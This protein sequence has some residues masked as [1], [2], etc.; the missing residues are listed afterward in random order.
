MPSLRVGRVGVIILLVSLKVERQFQGLVLQLLHELL[1]EHKEFPFE[2]YPIQEEGR[3]DILIRTSDGKGFCVVELKDP[4]AVPSPYDAKAWEQ[5]VKYATR[6][7]APYFIT[8]N[9]VSAVVWDRSKPIQ[10]SNIIDQKL[11]LSP[12]EVSLYRRERKLTKEG[13]RKLKDFLLFTLSALLD[14]SRGKVRI[15]GL[16][17]AFIPRIEELLERY[18][19]LVLAEGRIQGLYEKDPSFREELLRYIVEEQGWRFSGQLEDFE[20]LVRLALLLLVTKVIFYKALR[21]QGRRR[22]LPEFYP[23][24]TIRKMSPQKLLEVL[25]S[26]NEYFGYVVGRID[27][28]TLLGEHPNFLDRLP[29][30]SDYAPRFFAELAERLDEYDFSKIPVDVVGKIFEKLIEEDRRHKMG[31]YFTPV[32]VVDLILGYAVRRGTEDVLDAGSGSGT[33]S[34]RAYERKRRLSGKPHPEL[35]EHL[36]AVEIAPYPAHLTTLNLVIRDLRYPSYPRVIQ[37]DFFNL[38]PGSKVPA[39]DVRGRKITIPLP[40]VD[41]VVSNPPYTRQ[42]EMEEIQKGLK[43]RAHKRAAEDWRKADPELAKLLTKRAS[44]YTHFFLHG[45]AFLKP[46]GRLGFVTSNSWLDTDYG[47]V[48]QALLLRHFKLFAVIDSAVERWFEAADVNTCITLA[49]RCESEKERSRNLVRFVSLRAPLSEL[50]EG[51][52]FAQGFLEELESVSEPGFYENERYRVFA[53][54][55]GELLREA[56][57]EE[58]KFTGAKWGK[59]LRAPR[60]YF[61]IL[62]RAKDRLVPLGEIAEV[63]RGFTTGANKFFYVKDITAEFDDERARR[64]FGMSLGEIKARGLAII[65]SGD[66]SIHLIEREY[67]RP[68]VKSLREVK[69]VFVDKKDVS[70]FIVIFPD[71]DIKEFARKY[72]NYGEAQ[73]YSESATCSGR[74]PWFRLPKLQLPLIGISRRFGRRFVVFYSKEVL[75]GDNIYAMYPPSIGLLSFL[76]SFPFSLLHISYG[77]QMSAF[78]SSEVDAISLIKLPVLSPKFWAHLEENASSTLK[79]MARRRVLPILQELGFPEKAR[80][81]KTKEYL[82]RLNCSQ[83]TLDKVKPDRLELDRAVLEAMGFTDP[84]ERD[85]VLLELY[86]ELCRLVKER[87]LKASSV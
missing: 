77:Y 16:D 8:W 38:I 47:K 7:G 74:N 10:E 62:E 64:F 26:P 61:K 76:N 4:E 5:A 85:E 1:R 21:E 81:Q 19:V 22:D 69:S 33:F 41:A 17:E 58:G 48:I 37:N 32:P 3:A 35:L 28:E 72:I 18:T 84:K 53:V 60:V 14:L 87:L 11:V 56:T 24:D 63:R 20:R 44:L 68:V 70:Q 66:G 13:Q 36:W 75:I 39:R 52:E 86:R 27:Y 78:A 49:Q 83:I 45:A 51:Q 55:Q 79:Q 73:G 34:V 82:T 57:D 43:E 6:L 23:P 67:L 65:Q 15:R 29:F 9:I 25:W 54:R 50:L 59:F 46:G 12:L 40:K 71:D 80:S 30:L 42:E 31:Q 2:T